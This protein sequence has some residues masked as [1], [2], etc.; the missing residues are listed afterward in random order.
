MI[1]RKER[2]GNRLVGG[3]IEISLRRVLESEK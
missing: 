2:E 3:P 1:S